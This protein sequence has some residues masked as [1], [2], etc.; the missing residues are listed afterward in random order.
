MNVDVRNVTPYEGVKT[1]ALFKIVY[2]ETLATNYPGLEYTVFFDS[3]NSASMNNVYV[4]IQTPDQADPIE[5]YYPFQANKNTQVLS[6]TL[7]SN[8][9]IFN[10]VAGGVSY[11][12]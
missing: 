7:K 12:Q 11:W 2:D 1:L 3:F 4:A 10:V 9:R 8:G 6:V 5:S